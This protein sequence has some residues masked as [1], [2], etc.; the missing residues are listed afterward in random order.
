MSEKHIKK[1]ANV[2]E[3]AYD[4]IEKAHESMNLSARSFMKI[5]KVSRTIADLEESEQ[6]LRKHV[7]EACQYRFSSFNI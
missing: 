7:L 5:L 2:S 1:Y 3:E 4:T 6:V